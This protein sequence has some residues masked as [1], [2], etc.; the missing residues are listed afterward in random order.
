MLLIVVVE[1]LS[2]LVITPK[3]IYKT[4]PK[5]NRY[6]VGMCLILAFRYN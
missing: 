4:R 3:E 5:S 1:N 2:K 6:A